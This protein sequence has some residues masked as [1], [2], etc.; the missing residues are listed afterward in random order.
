[1]TIEGSAGTTDEPIVTMTDDKTGTMIFDD[2]SGIV[3]TETMI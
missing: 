1:M 2:S 3:A